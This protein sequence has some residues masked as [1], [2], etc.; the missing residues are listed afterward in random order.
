ME[1]MEQFIVVIPTLVALC[2][3]W[4]VK[5]V[6]PSD[7]VNRFI[8]LIAA[9][10]GVGMNIW[11]NMSFTPQVLVGGLVSGLLQ[12]LRKSLLR[13]IKYTSGIIIEF[14]STT[15]LAGNH[16]GTAGTTQ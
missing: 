8:P 1:T 15:M 9:A 16:A 14:I 6:I 12:Q 10:V 2:V 5:H 4:L 13:T 3:G 11:L 7:A